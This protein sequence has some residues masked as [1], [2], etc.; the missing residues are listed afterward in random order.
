MKINFN[1]VLQRD[2]IL[3]GRSDYK[4]LTFEER[5]KSMS[6]KEIILAMVES[7]TLPPTVNVQMS[8][9]GHLVEIKKRRFLFF[10]KR[11]VKH[12]YGCAATNTIC[13]IANIS[14]F[15]L[16]AEGEE[17][18]HNTLRSVTFFHPSTKDRADNLGVN[19]DFLHIFEMAIDALRQGLIYTYNM[20][21]EEGKFAC[22]K[23]I[24]SVPL[25]TNGYTRDE[26]NEY[27]KL[28]DSQ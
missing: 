12:C 22:I 18:T 1:P 19:K 27:R 11:T 17:T 24:K 20:Y 4:S 13:R 3:D 16:L 14:P 2:I 7:L 23:P 25:L 5:V 28:A 8:S 26:L 15:K 10:G 21:A 6:A 9:F